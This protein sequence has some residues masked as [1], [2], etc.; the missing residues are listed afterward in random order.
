[1]NYLILGD[2]KLGTE[3]HRQTGWDYIS[4]KKDS[5]DFMDPETYRPFLEKN[6]DQ[7]INCI[8][9]TKTYE[10]ERNPN[11]DLNYLGV[12]YLTNMC[13][14]YN[15][16][17]IHISTD[18]VYANS[19]IGHSED[20]I[21]VHFESWYSYTKLLGDAY[22]QALATNYLLIRTNFKPRPF[23]WKKA[24]DDIQGNFDYVDIIAKLIIDLI[25]AKAT[26][27]YNVG[28]EPKTY[29]DLAKQT[30]SDCIKDNDG[31]HHPK[32]VTMNLNKLH[33]V[34]NSI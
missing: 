33:N 3:L 4:R 19:T 7:I 34:K 1:M 9:Y 15:K 2:G 17:L 24:W 5:I 12:M 26:G 14:N 20:D 21:P 25:K 27:V 32:D 29:Y 23:P 18:Y 10:K 16:K 22:V 11:W 8:G 30:L 6:Y 28:T 13:N 31:L